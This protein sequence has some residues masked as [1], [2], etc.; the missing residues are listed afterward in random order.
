MRL[1]D[2]QCKDVINVVTGCKIGF[3]CDVIVDNCCACVQAIVVEKITF[4]RFFRFFSA[5]EEVIIPINNIVNIGE[6]VILVNI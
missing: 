5:I 1:V 2:M 3:V 4:W 6:D